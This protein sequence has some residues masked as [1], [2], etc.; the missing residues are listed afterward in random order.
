M[1]V[2]S[3]LLKEF[4]NYFGSELNHRP[5][6]GFKQA[7]YINK[8][9]VRDIA[10]FFSEKMFYLKNIL[11]NDLPQS[12]EIIYEYF[13]KML[14]E[15]KNIFIFTHVDKASNEIDSVRVAYPHIGNYEDEVT[16]RYG[17]KFLYFKEE[18]EESLYLDTST[19]YPSHSD[20]NLLSL[21]IFNKIHLNNNYFHL[22]IEKDIIKS[23]DLKTGWLYRGII[24]LLKHKKWSYENL[25]LIEKISFNNSFH[26]NLAYS[27]ALESI[28]NIN[29]SARVKLL[30][31]VYCELE[32][33]SNHMVWFSNLMY[34]LKYYKDYYSLLSRH[35]Y[36][37]KILEKE[38]G[39]VYFENLNYIGYVKD[40]PWYSI[41]DLKNKVEVV[42]LST[43][44]ILYKKIYSS[45]FKNRCKKL[46]V[47]SHD[48]A[49]ESGIVGPNLRASGIAHDVRQFT[50]YNSYS[51]NAVI[52]SWEVVSF[53]DGDIF[54]RA[55]ARL[56]EIKNSNSII[57]RCLEIVL[58]DE[59]DITPIDLSKKK[60]NANE[61]GISVVEAPQGELV[62]V[63]KTGDRPGKDELGSVYIQTPSFNNFFALKNYLIPNSDIRDF[64]LIVHSMDLCFNCI[65]L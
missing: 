22:K 42:V 35:L 36:L 30:R 25:K 58:K 13:S 49:I 39:S 46:G 27:L 33:I 64:P 37:L 11:I 16:K 50:P 47:I 45:Y 57:Q 20:N 53:T 55:Q 60:L 5:I 6:Q 1:L 23:V 41:E 48:N 24:P 19:L 54:S 17:L 28:L 65:D 8:S 29:T 12:Y 34:L 21:G 61:Y 52:G 14:Q 38:L 59:S 7:Y 32:R 26:H 40:I 9:R 51:D 43:F 2:Y 62:Y 10:F 4:K 3:N 31:T 44:G 15:D 18:M 63:V 56:W